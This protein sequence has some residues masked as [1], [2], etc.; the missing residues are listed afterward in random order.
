MSRTRNTII[1]SLAAAL[2]VAAAVAPG[3]TAS[4]RTATELGQSI[5]AT[6]AATPSGESS[7]RTA[8]ELGQ[9]TG[10]LPS[11]KPGGGSSERTVTELGQA[12]GESADGN[13]TRA[14][15]ADDQDLRSLRGDS[16]AFNWG[17]AAIVA[18]GGLGL[19]IGVGGIVL[20]TRRRGALRRSRTP[21]VSS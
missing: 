11:A 8:T 5:G 17:D 10:G 4:E 3:A 21:V 14:A 2:M 6:P 18:S 20:F 9:S 7:G 16:G 12:V 1:G 19:L 15:Q 13:L